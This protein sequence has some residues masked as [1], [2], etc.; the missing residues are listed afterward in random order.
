MSSLSLTRTALLKLRG[1]S[2]RRGYVLLG[3]SYEM[4]GRLDKSLSFYQVGAQLFPRDQD[5][6]SRLAVLLHRSGLEEQAQPLF[7]RLV[8]RTR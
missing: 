8:R 3:A 5:L 2:L 6:L 7:E 4:T 1:E